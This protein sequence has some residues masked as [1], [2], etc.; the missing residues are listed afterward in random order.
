M[1]KRNCGTMKSMAP[2]VIA[3]GPGFRAP[4]DV[5][6]VV[7]TMRGHDLGRVITNGEAAPNTGIP[8][9]IGGKSLDRIVRSPAEGTANF[10]VTIGDNVKGGQIIGSVGG[11]T[12]NAKI[13]AR[14]GGVVRG[15]I[16]PSVHVMTN[17]K[18]GDIDPRATREN[19]FS[20][21]DKSLAVAGGVLEAV[22]S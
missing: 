22:L 12:L 8:S 20:I 14:T 1:A 9:E 21:S 17:M 18:I 16:H 2:R 3:I 4:Q 5:H 7:E 15:L 6:A 11:T 13:S 19:C 10:T